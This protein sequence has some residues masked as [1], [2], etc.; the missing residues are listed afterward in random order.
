MIEKIFRNCVESTNA[1]VREEIATLP[2]PCMVY[3]D[4][5]SAGRGQRG[6]RWLSNKSENILCSLYW[7][8]SKLEAIHQFSLSRAVALAVCGALEEEYGGSAQIK[9]P[10]DIYVGDKKICGIL[11]ENSLRG[12]LIDYTTIGI[13]LN[14]NQMDFPKELPNP[15]SIAMLK[16]EKQDINNLLATLSKALEAYLPKAENDEGRQELSE[17]YMNHLWRNDGEM[18]EFI[19]RTV[20]AEASRF[21]TNP[22]G[23]GAPHAYHF[24]GKIEDVAPAGY[25]HLRDHEGV[26]RVFSFKEVEFVI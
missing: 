15:V 25:L 14:V 17:L 9:W 22:L 6:N 24:K 18:H 21:T 10:N 8:P 1:Q 2:C 3:T 4:Y 20:G 7:R 5:Q 13:G 23:M 16:G 19:D 12:A 26:L 11:I